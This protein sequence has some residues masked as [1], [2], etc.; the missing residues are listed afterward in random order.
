M[1]DW[2]VK[3]RR[4]DGSESVLETHATEDEA[5][6]SAAL[7]NTHEQTNQYYAEEW[8]PESTEWPNFGDTCCGKCAGA[9]CYVD[10]MT[11]ERE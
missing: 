2:V 8:Q 11:G 7:S 5:K 10:Y 1:G 9:G 4:Y 6:A 3:I